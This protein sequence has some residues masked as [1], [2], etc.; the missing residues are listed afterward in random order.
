MHFFV[1]RM[2]AEDK[3]QHRVAA[4]VHAAAAA[5]TAV[6]ASRRNEK[7]TRHGQREYQPLIGLKLQQQQLRLLV[8][9]DGSQ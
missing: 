6:A 9:K 1:A 2:H 5:R 7:E 8:I 3:R 4:V